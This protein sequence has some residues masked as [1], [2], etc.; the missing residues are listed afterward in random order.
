ML[1]TDATAVTNANV[2]DLITFKEGTDATGADIALGSVTINAAK[3]VI[4]LQPGANF[5]SE[6]DVF[7]CVDPVEDE[8]GNESIQQCATFKTS[9]VIAPVV[10]WDP[11]NGSTDVAIAKTI[12]L[13]FDDP[14]RNVDNTELTSTNVDSLITL[15]LNDANGVTVPFGATVSATMDTIYVDPTALLGSKTTYYAAIGATVEDNKNNAIL[16]S[17]STFITVD[18]EAPAVALVQ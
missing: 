13:A 6:I 9:D 15:K 1:K 7:M 10:T 5:A 4:T 14:V 17:S 2:E 11:V 18:S 3:T 8:H 16:A 12:S